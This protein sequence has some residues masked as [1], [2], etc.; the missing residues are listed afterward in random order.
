MRKKT[1]I[2]NVISNRGN[3]IDTYCRKMTLNDALIFASGVFYG[4][5]LKTKF[6][7]VELSVIE[8]EEPKKIKTYEKQRQYKKSRTMLKKIDEIIALQSDYHIEY[9]LNENENERV[10]NGYCD[11]AIIR[12]KKEEIKITHHGDVFIEQI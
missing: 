6:P 2:I 8:N 7:I 9:I 10:G 5:N 11:F 12:L 4:L 1:Y 3:T